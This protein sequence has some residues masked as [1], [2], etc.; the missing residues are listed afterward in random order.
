LVE[1]LKGIISFETQVKVQSS[2]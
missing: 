2:Q 1:A